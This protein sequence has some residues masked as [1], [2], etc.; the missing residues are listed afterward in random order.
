MKSDIPKQ[1]LLLKGRPILFYTLEA[2]SRFDSSLELIL[3]LPKS[4]IDFWEGLVKDHTFNVPHKIVEGGATRYH[5]VG[6]GLEVIPTSSGALVA[7]HDGV[8]C[9][10][11]D[12]VLASVSGLA[13]TKGNATASVPSKDSLRRVTKSGNKSVDRA[14]YSLIQTPQVFDVSSLKLAFESGY[15]DHFTDDASVFEY[16]GHDIFLSEGSYENIKITTPEDLLIAEA[17]L[18]QRSV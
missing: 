18:K 7:I 4:Q 5:S 1:F 12:V 10:V 3:V 8:R 11:D 14:E 9:L 15:H 6:N 2:F 17:I 13:K 16:A